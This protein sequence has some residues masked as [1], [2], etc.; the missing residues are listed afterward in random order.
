M[1]GDYHMQ[2]CYVRHC[3]G[4]LHEHIGTMM[5]TCT[6]DFCRA[7][8]ASGVLAMVTKPDHSIHIAPIVDHVYGCSG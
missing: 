8:I 6:L 3:S 1:H 2:N 5:M 7:F 4:L